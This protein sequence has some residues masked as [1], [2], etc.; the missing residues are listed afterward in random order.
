MGVF[1]KGK[2]WYIDYY[3]Q[4][5]RRR[6]EM[7]G[8][9][10]RQAEIVLQKRKVEVAEGKF[11]D[12][13]KERTVSFKEM[14]REYIE[15]YSR[16][17]KSSCRRDKISVKHLLSFFGEKAL[18]NI[19]PLDVEKYKQKR[20]KEVAPSTVNRE[21]A[22]LKA[23]FNKAK[24]LE[25]EEITKLV[26]ACPEYMKSIVIVA[27]N[28]G[29]RRG[30]LLK[31]KWN[32]IDFRNRIIYILETKN[33]EIRKIPMNNVTFKTLLKVRKNPKSPYVFCKKD[34]SP[35]KDIR[36]SFKK[37]LKK[38][39]I[40]NFRFHDLRH[41]FASHLVMAGVDLK[42]V[43]ELL[44]HKTFTMTLRY[45]HLSPDHKRR[46]VDILGRRMDTIWTPGQKREERISLAPLS[47]LS[48]NNAQEDFAGVAELADAVDL[49]STGHTMPVPVRVRP[50][51]LDIKSVD[52][53]LILY[54]NING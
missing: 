15:V 8:P 3:D 26:E 48:Y 53:S 17:N 28:T 37:A 33:N 50:P 1:K 19:S 41:T 29:M 27:L 7:I 23:I 4:N 38:A 10:K 54:K 2:N 47:K 42:T 39:G 14:A 31:L 52:F 35:Y 20:V 49:K 6:R 36:E 21:I 43:Q 40:Q 11:L 5:R 45:S 51:A 12:I 22:C 13:R 16:P 9:N 25:K 30:E 24:E 44:G 46:A 18:Q 34:G 32:D